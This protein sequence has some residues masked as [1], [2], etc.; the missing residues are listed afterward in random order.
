MTP[1]MIERLRRNLAA[2]VRA[3]PMTERR[4]A[5]AEVEQLER[6]VAA[7]KDQIEVLRKALDRSPAAE[8]HRDYHAYALGADLH[9]AGLTAAD[10]TALTGLWS[11]G[12]AN[13]AKLLMIAAETNP[14]TYV[15]R[16]L[17]SILNAHRDELEARGRLVQWRRRWAAYQAESEAWLASDLRTRDGGWRDLHMTSPQRHLIRTTAL[18]LKIDIPELRSRGEAHDWLNTYGANLVYR[19]AF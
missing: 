4:Q 13:V 18:L 15:L 3:D 14:A 8:P 9:F 17:P 10:A 11:T 6:E 12:P 19:K 16:L 2:Q 1:E 5:S 7:T